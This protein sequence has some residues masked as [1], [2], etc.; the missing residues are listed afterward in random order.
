[1]G[2]SPS[3][4]ILLSLAATYLVHVPRS[5]SIHLPSPAAMFIVQV[6]CS[7]SILLPSLVAT[8]LIQVLRSRATPSL[9]VLLMDSKH[10]LRK[11]N[12]LSRGLI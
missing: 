10:T 11:A 5:S 3:I 12:T 6:P 8:I 1:M 4:S 9:N 7:S 2:N